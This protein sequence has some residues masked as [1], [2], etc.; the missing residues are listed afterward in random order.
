MVEQGLATISDKELETYTPEQLRDYIQHVYNMGY[1]QGFSENITQ[2]SDIVE[3]Q[4][5]SY[6]EQIAKVYKEILSKKDIKISHF[7]YNSNVNLKEVNILIAFP[8]SDF[9]HIFETVCSQNISYENIIGKNLKCNIDIKCMSDSGI[10]IECIKSD[11]RY[12][13]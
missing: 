6:S 8:D 4:F 13:L 3:K 9:D 1:A 12:Q 11:Y 7:F 5:I 10:N 2:W